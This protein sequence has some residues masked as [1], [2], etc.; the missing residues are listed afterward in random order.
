MPNTSTS[1]QWS[2][3]TEYAGSKSLIVSVG[4]LLVD[5]VCTLRDPLRRGTDAFSTNSFRQ[6]GSAAN[7]AVAAARAGSSARFVGGLGDDVFADFLTGEMVNAG[8]E[9]CAP[10]YASATTGTVVVLVEP[11]GERTMAPDRGA[12]GL[13]SPADR[14]WL[15]SASVIH[16]PL[17][18]FEVEPLASTAITLAE[19]ARDAGVPVSV[20]LS[21]VSLLESLG[22][23]R[24]NALAAQLLPQVVFANA[25]ESVVA[26]DFRSATLFVEKNGPHPVRC[27]ANGV[28]N[29][30]VSVPPLADVRN[31]TGAGDA[32]AAGFLCGFSSGLDTKSCIQQGSL[33]A[34]NLLVP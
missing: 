19:W 31:T 24:V 32:F 29:E 33:F 10:R 22:A 2:S 17:Y 15:V 4:D 20:D 13:L 14:A 6:G 12:S 30:T 11:D 21:A 25:D 9:L 16:I 28:L 34:A 18:A 1:E 5:V 27:F 8:V 23:N 26:G 7:V 3:R